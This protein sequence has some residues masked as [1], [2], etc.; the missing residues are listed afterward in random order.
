MLPKLSGVFSRV[1]SPGVLS[2]LEVKRLLVSVY[3]LGLFVI[4]YFLNI[5][6]LPLFGLAFASTI[7]LP[8]IALPSK[9]LVLFKLFRYV[10]GSSTALEKSLFWAMLWVTLVKRLLII[11]PNILEL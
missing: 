10:G 5:D 6:A 4:F 7:P 2:P 1:L 3:E 11:P 8:T 9:L